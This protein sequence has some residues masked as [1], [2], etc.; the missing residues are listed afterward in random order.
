[1]Q[2]ENLDVWRRSRLFTIEVYKQCR[3]LKDFGFKDQIT[4]SALS[5]PSKI[6]EGMERY[7]NP[8]KANF[9]VIAKGSIGEFKTQVDIGVEIGYINPD[10]GKHWMKEAEAISKMLGSLIIRLK[11]KKRKPIN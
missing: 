9:L 2:Y 11:N 10:L 1:M 5:V 3:G 7:T 6:A 4:R 8:D